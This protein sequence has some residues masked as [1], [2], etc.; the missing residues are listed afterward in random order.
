MD[1]VGEIVREGNARRL[2]VQDGK[3]NRVVEVPLTVGVVVGVVAPV[4]SLA[5]W[6]AGLAAGWTFHVERDREAKP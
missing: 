3:G 6:V 1:G 2:V 4:V 5:G